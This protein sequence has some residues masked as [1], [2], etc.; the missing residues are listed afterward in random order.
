MLGYLKL[1]KNWASVIDDSPFER[2]E[3]YINASFATHPDGKSQ[4][5]CMVFLG[6]TLA[7]EGCRKQKLIMKCSTESELVALAD[8]IL[9]GEVLWTLVK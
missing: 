2:V 4:S 3:T 7:H 5:G 6:N 9:E 8:Y 1:L